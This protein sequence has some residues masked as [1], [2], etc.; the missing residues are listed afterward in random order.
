MPA[1]ILQS[2][3]GGF[4]GT[5]G[6]ATLPAGTTAGTTLILVVGTASTSVSP[7]PPTGFTPVNGEGPTPAANRA[8]VF[9]K[10]NVAAGETSWTVAITSAQLVTW[11]VMEV[12]GLD[13]TNPKDV[14]TATFQN[15]SAVTSASTSTS[16]QSTAYDV[17]VVAYHLGNNTT[18]TTIPTW[19]GQTGGF[20]EVTDAGVA[21]A[22]T[23]SGLSVSVT[24]SQQ[25]STFAC[26][27]TASVTVNTGSGLVVYAAAGAKRQAN[28]QIMAGFEWGT[29]AGLT[30]G[31]GAALGN[32]IFDSSAGTPAIV[33]SP[34]P[35]SGAYALELSASA[36]VE[37]VQ[38][39][40]SAS[41]GTASNFFVARVCFC[42]PG[43][44]PGADVQVL[45]IHGASGTPTQSGTVFYRS[46]SQ[47]IG[48]R[49]TETATPVVGTEQLSATTVVADTWYAIDL[50]FDGSSTSLYA[51]DWQLDGVGQTRATVVP[52]IGTA[53]AI[54][55]MTLGWIASSTAT[56]R[57][58][59]VVASR[60]L[61]HYPL[62]DFR[63]FPLKPDPAGTLTISG[64]A[65]NFNTFSANGTM[66][67]W[68]AA[69]A[70]AAI[71]DLPP[72][73][74]ASADG[75]AQITA[76]ATDY[77]NIPMETYDAVSG[78][79]AARAVRMYAC[80]WGAGSPA[81][82]TI[83]FRGYEGTTET[84][85][86]AAAD[87]AF[88]NSTTTP[89]WVCKMFKPTGGWTQAKLD[90]LAF[91]VGFSGD[92]TPDIGIHSIMAEVAVRTGE[93]RTLF[94]DFASAT[95]DPDSQGVIQVEVIAPVGYPA[96]L[97]YEIGGSP[98]QVPVAG[99]TTETETIDAP[100]AP[101]VKRIT[102]YCAN[103]PEPTA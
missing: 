23:A 71:D 36:A 19:S 33:T 3:A 67:A 30:T 17:F 31:T 70:L 44:L 54:A 37:Y 10:S 95:V 14:A 81:A 47:K 91:R 85:L 77:V 34:R 90:A 4:N 89:G 96:T 76:A 26:T 63:I 21:G 99:G 101:T 73:I 7:N 82:A 102:L 55:A 39:T 35:G 43:S 15:G 27:A 5:S 59:D 75:I 28:V 86:M 58:D 103:E 78:G 46:A 18:N 60:T 45:S 66:A 93:T 48:V 87:P 98:T 92:A 9:R 88:T 83:G 72:T 79:S 12:D 64:T 8:F 84:V 51:I 52:A 40:G 42:F 74:G 100:D 80:G 11:S 68:N 94:G 29:V 69:T 97:E 16:P 56:I 62:G 41:L 49:V 65:A 13:L 24:T 53:G 38:W 20:T 6:N 2:N 32:Q 61:G 57:Y 50:A 22:S 25:L 1:T